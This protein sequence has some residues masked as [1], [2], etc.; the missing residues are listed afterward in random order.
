M[1][2]HDRL[3][4]TLA[5]LPLLLWKTP[6]ALEMILRQEGI[7]V[8]VLGD[9]NPFSLRAGRFVLYDG[10]N[11]SHRSLLA[12]LLPDHVAIDIDQYRQGEP[13]DPFQALV[14][15]RN[16]RAIWDLEEAS[17]SERI[18]ARPKAWIRRRLIDRLRETVGAAGGVWLRLSPYPHPYRSAFNFRVDLD[19][20]APDDYRR[21]ARAR[22]PLADCCT[23]FVSTHAY[24][25]LPS[26]LADL[27]RVDTQSH[28]HFHFVYRDALANRRNIA[29]AEVIL[30]DVGIPPT[31][32]AAPH[33]RWNHGLDDALEDAGYCYS[34]DFQV[35]YDDFPFF[36]WKEKRFSNVLQVPIHPV[37][38]GLFLEAGVRDPVTIAEYFQSVIE[39][40]LNTREPA[41]IYGH[42]ERRLA[43]MPG[44]LLHIARLIDGES[45]VWRTTLTEWA[46]WWRWR[47]ERRWMVVPREE[48]HFE[49]QFD[50]WD[51]E[52]PL[53]VEVHR[54]RFQCMIP[55]TGP[56]MTLR[57]EDLAYERRADSSE[58]SD[59]P[60]NDPRRPT[61]R[62][63]IR[64]MLDWET[65][66]PIE[67]LAG[68]SLPDRLKL[69]LR[70]WKL[71]RQGS[72]A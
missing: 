69:G 39:Q 45:L 53:A 21:F 25:G 46:R 70:W 42:P 44:V 7:P 72:E 56:R 38:E 66:T 20:P 23:H 52:Y 26:I 40:K 48:N 19:E 37:C 65:V 63:T 2:P 50:E 55:V 13:I 24:G 22:E 41:F 43:R 62:E 36:P 61:I 1:A 10:R 34:S 12:M 27:R 54:G 14:D 64:R 71:Q 32:F 51:S 68:N 49:I 47:G 58:Y 5:T 33:G 6:P 15:H 3:T 59:P 30:R 11:D 67:E 8:E 29:R 9:R 16:G 4:P 60:R 57:L 28:G 17:L 35:G 31:G 18:A